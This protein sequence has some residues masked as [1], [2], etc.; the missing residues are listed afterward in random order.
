[1]HVCFIA[2]QVMQPVS[3]G[4]SVQTSNTAEALQQN[5][6]TVTLFNPWQRYEWKQFDCVHIFRADFDT[7]NIAL[8][9]KKSSIPYVLT[10]IFY[11]AHPPSFIRLFL[12]LSRIAR[13]AVTGLRSELDCVRDIS[14]YADMVMP[15]TM[16]ERKYLQDG[17]G[18]TRQKVTV[19]P[20]GVEERFAHG[21]PSL[22]KKKYGVTDFILSVA[23]FGYPRKN[24][25]NLIHALS[26]IDHPAVL[27]GTIYDNDYGNACRVAMKDN[28]RILWLDALDHT[29]PMLAS[30]YAACKVYAQPSLLETPGLAA[31]EAAAAGASIVITPYGGPKEYF[32]TM[33]HYVDPR[34]INSIRMGISAT[35]EETAQPA[36][37]KHILDSYSYASIG[38]QLQIIYEKVIYRE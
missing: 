8:W 27:I 32:G 21:D 33:A 18:I 25:L 30:A 37:Q 16:A 4:V 12:L 23:N 9:L 31:L 3:G 28:K 22:F 10:P 6:V 38:R 36:L 34:D 17:M 26:T 24:M 20:N 19:I 15:N 13:K 5:G 7:Y 35:L 29:D 11:T 1:M 2:P 14:L